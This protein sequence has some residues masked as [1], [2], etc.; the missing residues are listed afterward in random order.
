MI[1]RSWDCQAAS[2]W[3][4]HNSFCKPGLALTPRGAKLQGE[5]GLL[6]MLT[7]FIWMGVS[8]LTM[9]SCSGHQ[10]LVF[11][12]WIFIPIGNTF[13]LVFGANPVPWVRGADILPACMA[14]DQ[15]WG[16]P[17]PLPVCA[18]FSWQVQLRNS[19]RLCLSV[20]WAGWHSQ[21]RGVAHQDRS[22]LWTCSWSPLPRVSWRRKDIVCFGYMTTKVPALPELICCENHVVKSCFRLFLL[23]YIPKHKE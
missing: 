13:E 20:V 2:P 17:L 6:K 23:D 5:D 1:S 16:C 15:R 22:Q 19:T 4:W 8:D 11:S 21:P 18:G 14:P 12:V 7:L 3:G 9:R 10:F